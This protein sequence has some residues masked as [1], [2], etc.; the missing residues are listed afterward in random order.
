MVQNDKHVPDATVRGDLA[1]SDEQQV[2][3]LINKYFPER[4]GLIRRVHP[5]WKGYVRINF[6][7]MS[8]GNHVTESHFVNVAEDGLQELN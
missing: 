8:Q 5:I 3:T 1:V 2:L 6:H 4:L 7:D